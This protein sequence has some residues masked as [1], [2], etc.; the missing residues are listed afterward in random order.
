MQFLLIWALHGYVLSSST[1]MDVVNAAYATLPARPELHVI[2][3]QLTLF[4]KDLHLSREM[5][6]Y[7]LNACQ[8]V[9]FN[10]VAI[11]FGT[12]VWALLG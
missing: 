11:Y 2:C 3:Q 7:S 6:T 10:V 12:F 1:D 9:Q 4:I 8:L 5:F